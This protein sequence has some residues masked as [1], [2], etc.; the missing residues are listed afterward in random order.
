MRE[1]MHYSVLILY[2]SA[3]CGN[4][5]RAVLPMQT[6]ARI[7]PSDLPSEVGVC[8]IKFKSEQSAI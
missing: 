5:Y 1:A 7:V 6:G 4:A 2:F 8:R 3:I